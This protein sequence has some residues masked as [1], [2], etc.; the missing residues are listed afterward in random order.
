M[1]SG[2][3]VRQG[4]LTAVSRA[5]IAQS[6]VNVMAGLLAGVARLGAFGLIASSVVAAWAGI[7]ALVRQAGPSTRLALRKVTPRSLSAA[8]QTHGRNASWSTLV[9][10]VNALSISAPLLLL[11]YF[12]LPRE[13]GWYALVN[14]LIAAPVGVLT[15]ALGQSFW[16]QAAEYARAKKYVDLSRL[17]RRTT[18][19]LGLASLPVA[20]ICLM[21]PLFVGPILGHKDWDGAGYVLM[22]MTP[23]FLGYML[24][25]PTNH[26]VVL[27]MQRTQLVVDL[28]RLLL[29]VVSIISA[30][31]LELG[32]AVAV[33]LTASSSFVGHALLFLIH[34]R[35]HKRH[36]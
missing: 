23:L 18:Y 9:S 4:D 7:G 13:V 28:V 14:R 34:I 12:Y 6:A 25:S 29:V 32:F 2:W 21:G 22:A 10:L 24:F 31:L 20:I 8:V 15:S 19:R 30:N 3:F 26:L 33:L 5:T 11:A 36:E 17:Y 35:V 1:F 27:D 16:S